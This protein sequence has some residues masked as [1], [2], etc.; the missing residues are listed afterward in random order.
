M[1]PGSQRPRRGPVLVPARPTG[2]NGT[3]GGE[4]PRPGGREMRIDELAREAGTTV[5]NVRAYRERGLLPPPR[6]EGRVGLYSEGHLARLRLI[7][8][9]LARGYSIANI[10]DLLAA[11]ERGHD[12]SDLLGLE[13]ALAV[14]WGDET[15]TVTITPAELLDLYAPGT[16]LD[17]VPEDLL[18][19]VREAVR[20]QVLDW[21]DQMQQYLVRRPAFLRAGAE[22]VRGGVPLADVV[23]QMGL[24]RETMGRLA[25]G[26][27]GLVVHDVVEPL[28][29]MPPAQALSQLADLIQRLRPL[30]RE[31]VESE[32]A[33]AMEH[34]V[35]AAFSAWIDRTAHGPNRR[36]PN[37][38]F[39][40]PDQR[41]VTDAAAP[42]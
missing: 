36:G 33:R 28:G 35:E 34:E 3:M 4:P 40:S 5:R 19:A 42:S 6:R 7:G 25:E 9:L 31:V 24:V 16:A 41:G 37:R 32:M 14:P 21:D 2:N 17:E 1:R 29:D 18:E 27:V 22:L 26:F 30:V 39:G 10:A 15:T 38:R 12:I 11:W 8:A 13:V 23:T 20:L